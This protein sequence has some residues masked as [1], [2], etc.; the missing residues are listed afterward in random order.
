[1]IYRKKY[2]HLKKALSKVRRRYS[3]VMQRHRAFKRGWVKR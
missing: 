3:R 2:R 1:M